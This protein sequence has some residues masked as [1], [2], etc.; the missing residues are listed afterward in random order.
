[1]ILLLMPML[2][3]A[4]QDQGRLTMNAYFD[5]YYSVFTDDL[6]LNEFQQYTTVSARDNQIGINAVQLGINYTNAFVRG[7]LTLHYGDI[8]KAT[9]SEDFEMVQ[10]GYAGIR[11]TEGLWLDAGF[12]TT[13]VGTESFLPKNNLLSSTAVATYI[14]PF[15]QSGARLSWEGGERFQAA[16]HVINGY[17]Q[18]LDRNRAKSYGV[19][20]SYDFN[21]EFSL[22]YASMLGRESEEDAPRDQYLVYQNVYGTWQSGLWQVIAGGDVAFQSNSAIDDPGESAAMVNFLT[23]VRYQVAQDF[24]VTGRFELYDDPDGFLSGTFPAEGSTRGLSMTGYTAG[25]EY[26]PFTTSFLRAET[27]YIRTMDDL[28]I[29][30]D[31]EATGP[32]RWEF[33][34][35]LGVY[36]E[37]MNL[38]P[39][40]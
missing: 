31:A 20:L 22:T 28:D 15:Y 16:F 24:S 34:I 35:T 9:W 37:E 14:G 7:V 30:T 3:G 17:N 8:A 25:V 19:Y 12:F 4:A 26:R 27:R 10:E 29:F 39:S 18:F 21:E 11:L 33:M 23:T 36:L 5:A 13:H 1:M 2:K 32:D 40:P 6:P 38:L